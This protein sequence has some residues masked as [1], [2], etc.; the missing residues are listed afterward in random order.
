MPG[1][2]AK[3]H[4][5]QV[6]Y[7]SADQSAAQRAEKRRM[8]DIVADAFARKGGI[9][10]KDCVLPDGTSG[11]QGL[12]ACGSRG[13]GKDPDGVEYG[14]GRADVRLSVD[15]DGLRAHRRHH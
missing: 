9:R 6:M 7:K 2:Q 14:G 5:V 13:H 3:I 4:E 8:F 10:S 11:P 1:K 12:V 15:G